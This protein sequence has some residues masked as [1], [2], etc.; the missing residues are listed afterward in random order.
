MAQ[1]FKAA[2]YPGTDDKSIT[3]QEADGVAL[4]AIQGLN[5]KV[6]SEN[7]ALR[8]ENDELK[9]RL[10]RIEQLKASVRARVEHAFRVLKRQFGYVK[11]RYRGLA[12]NTAQL[13]ALFALT[14]IWMARQK[15]LVTG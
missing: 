11:V 4:A 8:A 14:N 3:T 2:F 5:E 15:L 12:K 6:A 7:A 9:K 13:Q 10:E 1:D